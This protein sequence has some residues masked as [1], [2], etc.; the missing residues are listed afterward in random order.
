MTAAAISIPVPHTSPS[1]WAKW[2]SPSES[3]APGTCDGQQERRARDQPPDVEIAAVLARRDR[4]EPRARDRG[5][6]RLGRRSSADRPARRAD[7]LLAGALRLHQL[8][9]RRDTDHARVDARRA[10]RPPVARPSARRVAV[11]LPAHEERLREDVGEE[12]E[13]G[14]HRVDAEV[15]R[16][17]GE[18]L[19]LEHVARLGALDEE[20]AR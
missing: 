17:V 14:D 4:A 1:P 6:R 9:R 13:A 20:R 10:P 8:V 2:T 11:E 18:Q 16:L 12:P 19:D 7:P 5:E 15:R 3:S